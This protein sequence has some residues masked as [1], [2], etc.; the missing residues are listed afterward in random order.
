MEREHHPVLLP[1][2]CMET[3]EKEALTKT[4]KDRVVRHSDPIV[5]LLKFPFTSQ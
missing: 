1:S 2:S 4:E 3:L 5:D